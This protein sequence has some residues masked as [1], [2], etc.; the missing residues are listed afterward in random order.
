[1]Q[2]GSAFGDGEHRLAAQLRIRDDATDVARRVQKVCGDN[3]IGL[4]VLSAEA[5]DRA[6][7]HLSPDEI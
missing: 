5:V 2:L 1:M 7:A 4:K 6:P 3:G